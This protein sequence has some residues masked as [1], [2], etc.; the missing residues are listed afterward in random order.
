MKKEFQFS[1]F[2]CIPLRQFFSK[3]LDSDRNWNRCL[4]RKAEGYGPMK[5]WQ[6]LRLL[7]RRKVPIPSLTINIRADKS[8]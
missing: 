2:R 6:P 4:S 3:S 5:P 8:E 7:I 1:E